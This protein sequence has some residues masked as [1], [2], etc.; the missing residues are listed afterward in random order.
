MISTTASDVKLTCRSRTPP[1]STNVHHAGTTLLAATIA[2]RHRAIATS[3]M[4]GVQKKY[5]E[6][7]YPWAI[8]ATRKMA[9]MTLTEG[10]DAFASRDTCQS[11]AASTKQLNAVRRP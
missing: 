1:R 11:T 8:L 4:T 7:R 9:A 10:S 6:E 3:N 2:I 5:L